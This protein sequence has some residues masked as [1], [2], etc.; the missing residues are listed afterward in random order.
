[1]RLLI[2]VIL[3][4]IAALVLIGLG[5][6]AIYSMF[7]KKVEQGKVLIRNGSR[8]TRVSF[9][10]IFVFPVFHRI[11]IMDISVKRVEIQ[12][13]GKDGLVCQDNIR[14]D[15][16]V[17]F[18]VRVNKTEEDVLRVAQSIGCVRASDPRAL[19]ELFDSKF[20]EALKTVGK[21][22]DFVD[23]YTSRETF[24]N[25]ILQIIGT[26]LN[27]YVLDD[28]AIDYL[29]QTSVNTLNPDNILDA[30]GIKKI[31][32]LTAKQR[33]LAN[34]IERE[35]EKI[36]TKQ[37][38]E[39]REAV[40]EL[41]RQ[42]AETEEKQKREISAIKSRE[43]AE[44][45]KIMS[46]EHLK[47]E[48]ARITTDEEVKIAEEQKERQILV[49]RKNRERT[50]KV[51]TERVE[52]DRALE[53]TERERIVALAQIEK[54]KALELERRAIQ[55]VIR[56]RV[57]VEKATVTEEEKIKDTRAYAEAE[58]AKQVKLIEAERIAQEAL[59]KEVRAAEAARQSAELK[60]RQRI[61]EAEAE[62]AAAQRRSE[63]MK[64]LAEAR[65]AEEAVLGISEANVMK[66]KAEAIQEQ[67][68]AEALVI[69]QKATAEAKGIEAH[70]VA[71]EK[72]GTAE[73][74]I[75]QRKL[76][77]EAEGITQKAEAMRKLDGVG[78]EHEEFKLR[79]DK[80]K[81]VE[82]ASIHIRKDIAEA[83]AKVLG[84]AMKSAKIDIVGGDGAFF[85]QITNAITNGKSIDRLVHNSEVL[86]D[87]KNTFFNGNGEH[88]EEELR[89]LIGRFGLRTEDIKNLTVSAVLLEI[90][91]RIDDDDHETRGRLNNLLAG[92][93]KTLLGSKLTDLVK[94]G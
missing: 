84:E 6:L 58:R 15:I 60:A 18:F 31:T 44:A 42:L 23:L 70:A 30:E 62:Q 19:E 11:E 90:L 56:E 73:A 81:T 52:K 47:A 57:V 75:L 41:Q 3:V 53:A 46:E 54:E 83:Q 13:T 86:S 55:D 50:D 87:V 67:G 5:F 94:R 72:Q 25:E 79:L 20:S 39:A 82:L 69:E 1:M 51:E 4:V 40:L 66:A 26:D 89:T 36:I 74:T 34:Q 38:V 22:F 48:R 21:R 32:D 17:V 28:A 33:I 10:G 78:K 85:N 91:G 65:A 80:E 24:K 63:A 14:A 93:R 77:A 76:V 68:R 71:T 29:E 43:Q 16:K 59:V 27:G 61:I 35:K 2:A 37:D 9:E 7:Y 88:F 49:A 92:A 12:R 64:T 8:G 45:A